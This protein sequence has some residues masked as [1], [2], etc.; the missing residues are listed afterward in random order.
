MQ[1]MCSV[2]PAYREHEAD[3]PAIDLTL[4]PC[5]RR[6][7]VQR[8]PTCCSKSA[9]HL[10][11]RSLPCSGTRRTAR[12]EWRPGSRQHLDRPTSAS[13]RHSAVL[14]R[15]ADGCIARMMRKPNGARTP[16]C[17]L[18][19]P[20]RPCQALDVVGSF[21]GTGVVCVRGFARRHGCRRNAGGRGCVSALWGWCVPADA[22]AYFGTRPGLAPGRRHDV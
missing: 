5:L 18:L 1:V 16:R 3:T 2:A 4:S 19:V 10:P 11:A 20:L 13:P 21:C 12:P 22:Q 14:P 7:R 8:S 9:T 17:C 6:H 15:A